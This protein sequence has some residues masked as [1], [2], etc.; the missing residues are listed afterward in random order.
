MS[1]QKPV[2]QADLLQAIGRALGRRSPPRSR[3]VRTASPGPPSSPCRPKCLISRDA[4]EGVDGR[5]DRLQRMVEFYFDDST[6]AARPDA[7]RACNVR[8]PTA[9]ARAAH[10]LAGTLVYLASTSPPWWP[11]DEW[12]TWASRAT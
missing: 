11:H 10:R 6:A 7:R 9:I 8:T 12:M 1:L 2:T 4:L 3:S 5:Y